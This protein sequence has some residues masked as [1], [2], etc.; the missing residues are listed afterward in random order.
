MY[1]ETKGILMLDIIREEEIPFRSMGLFENSCVMIP[2][3]ISD[4]PSFTNF[5]FG[6]EISNS[7]YFKNLV[8][9]IDSGNYSYIQFKDEKDK[10]E[11]MRVLSI[12]LKQK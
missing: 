3:K 12:K 2:L 1:Y 6:R 5:I 10:T 7:K 4:D 11:F 8:Q 9:L